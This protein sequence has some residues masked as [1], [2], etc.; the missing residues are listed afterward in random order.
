MKTFYRF[1]LVMGIIALSFTQSS[2]AQLSGTKTI[3]GDYATITAAITDLNT[4]G[5]GAGGV[6]FNVAAGFTE[7]ASNLVITATG[8]SAN[9][10]VFQ[11][12]GAGA[13]PLIT[14]GV[15]VGTMDGIIKLSGADYVTFDGFNLVDP[16]TNTTTT[17]QME[18]GFALLKVDGTNGSQYNTIRNCSITLQKVNTA[19][20]GIYSANHT[21]AATTALTVTSRTGSNSG[22]KYYSNYIQNCY[23]GFWMGGY[24]D[25][26]V[27]YDYYD[28]FNQIGVQGG[29]TI[30]YFG[31]GAVT[32]YGIYTIY[33]DSLAVNNNN[34]AGGSGTTTTGYGIMIST[35]NN[36]SVLVYNNTVSDTTSTTTSSTYGIALSNAGVGG[37]DNTVIVKRNTVQNMASIG[38]ITS[39][40]L[41]GFYIYY[42]VSMNLFV[43]SNKFINNKWGTATSTSTGSIYGIYIYPYTTTP[44]PGSTESITNNYVSG[45]NRKQSVVGTGTYYG[46]YIYYGQAA[47]E[48]YNNVVENDTL[49][50]TSAAYGMYVYNYY[51]NSANY[52]NNAVRNIYKKDGST[53]AY[54]G[55]YISGAA[56][57]GT[58]NYYN[59]SVNNI[60]VGAA[61]ASIYGHYNAAASLTKN[62]YGNTAYAL[63]TSLAGSV[64]GIYQSAG[65]TT[66]LYK[67]SV[68]NL[69]TSTGFGYG[70]TVA[71]G[72]TN[73]VYNNFISDIRV[74]SLS[75]TLALM[76]LYLSGGTT[77]NVYYNTI[78]LKS[79]SHIAG[80]FG[81]AALYASSV[82]AV[83][84][85]NNIVVNMSTPG[86]TGGYSVAYYRSTSTLTT[87]SAL[88]NNNCFYAGTP[89]TSHIVYYDGTNYLRTL[90]DFKVFVS[91]RDANSVSESPPFMNVT[92]T[93]YN[94][95]INP[96]IATQCEGSGTVISS[97]ISIV[98]DYDGIARY[99]NPGYPVNPSYPPAGPDIGAGE[100]GGIP[101]DMNPP[102]IA[103]TPLNHTATT[104]ARNLTAT[105]TD[106][107]GVPTSGIGLPVLY[108][109]INS[110]SYAAVTAVSLG[111]NR[112]SFTFGAGVALGDIISYYICAQDLNAPPNIGAFPSGGAGGYTLNP[113]AAAIPPTSPSTYTISAVALSGDYTVGLTMFNKITGKNITFEKVVKKVMKEVPV[114]EAVKELPNEK[115]KT[116][117]KDDN[118]TRDKISGRT[119]TIEVEEISWIP[120]ENGVEY[121]G[122]L[123]VKKSENPNY[124]YPSG[125]NGIYAT[126]TAAVADLNLRGVNGATRF[127]LNDASYTTGE[128]FPITVNVAND[129]IPTA[130]NT[131]T[132]KPNT[133]VTAAVSGAAASSRIFSIL[134]SY[135]SIDGS[136]TTNGTTRDLTIQNTSVTA[137]Q[138][139]LFGSKGTTPVTDGALKNCNIINGVNTSSAIVISDG[140]TPGT[141]GYFNNITI[142]NNSV[143]KAYIGIYA[144][145]NILAGNGSINI[146]ANNLNYPGA[147]AIRT[148]AIYAQGCN[149]ASVSNNYLGND[150]NIVDASN[151]TGIWFA[152]GTSN[153]T[154]SG[155]NISNIGGTLSGPRGIAI[156][157]A[158]PNANIVISG[159]TISGLYTPSSGVTYGIYAFSTT[160][161]VTIEKNRISNLRN[162]SASGYSAIGIA[163]ASTLTT[164]NTTVQNNFIWDVAAYGYGSTTTD[165]G[166]G[167]NIL[168]GGGYNIY[169]NSINLATDQTLATGNPAC[170]IISSSVVSPNSLDIRDNIFA[171]TSTLGTNRY[172]VLCNA[173]STVFS[174]LNNNDYYSTGPNLGRYNSAD[175]LDLAAWRT[176]LGKDSNSVSGDPKFFS[177]ADLHIMDSTSTTPVS[178]AGTPIAGL[179]TDLDGD[180]RNSTV[181]D[182]GADQFTSEL[183]SPAN[184]STGLENA[185]RLV[186]TKLTPAVS[187]RLQIATDTTSGTFV[188][189]TNVTDTAYTFLASN[190]KYY[191]RVNPVFAVYGNG[192]FSPVFNFS[193]LGTP[194]RVTLV[195]PSN[196]AVDLPV[197]IRF[198][199]NKAYDGT[200][201][202]NKPNAGAPIDISSYFNKTAKTNTGN[203]KFSTGD[204]VR[205]VGNYL[206]KISLDTTSAPVYADST[207]TDT[208]VVLSGAPPNQKFFWNVSA[209]NEFGWGATSVWFNATTIPMPGTPVAVSPPLDATGLASNV[210]LVWTHSFKAATY[211]V[212][213]STD[214]L[215][216]TL[217]F[218]DSLKTD[219]IRNVPG[220]LKFTK[221]YWRVK[222]V[223]GAGI[224]DWAT[225]YFTTANTPSPV[226]LV[227][228]NNVVHQPVGGILFT[229]RNLV[230]PNLMGYWLEATTD[231]V[232]G[233]PFM[234][235]STLGA[236]DTSKIEGGWGYFTNYYWRVKAKNDVNWGEYSI[237]FKFQTE[238]GPPNLVYPANNALGIV[239]T[240]TLDWDNAPGAATYRMQLSADSTFASTIL[241]VGGWPTSQYTVPSGL[242][243]IL[244]NY[245]W[246]VNS[247]NVNGTSIYSPV[248]K[249]RTMG[250]PLIVNLV[251]PVNNSI[252]VPALNTVFNWN[253]G[254]DQTFGIV[255]NKGKTGNDGKDLNA[256]NNGKITNGTDEITMVS[257]YWFELVTD[258]VAMANLVQDTTLTDTTKTIASLDN[259]TDFY[260]RVKGK[261]EI[262]WGSFSV[263][264]KFTTTVGLPALLLPANTSTDI[265]LSPLLDWTNGA[266]AT[267]YDLQVS[268]DP[269][270]ATLVY[271]L[272][273]LPTSEYSLPVPLN[274]FTNY[275]WRVR[276]TNAN[277]TSP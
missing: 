57:T 198:I 216:G 196:G 140:I 221:Y 74:D 250:E 89:D 8:T 148:I 257:K 207:L 102:T 247:T 222:A 210:T 55:I 232:T 86:T 180:T 167:I 138:V 214:S 219:T 25:A 256:K 47:V 181:P 83:D 97:P 62:F 6:T 260:F 76:G 263:W 58:F 11:K 18:W 130:V 1:I 266:T 189:N 183:L 30:R 5:V 21:I 95:H 31:G 38:A 14:A 77:D 49:P 81:T 172:A 211:T 185:V 270:F 60:S 118:S 146:N 169:Y 80:L 262:G 75:S 261:N 269:G 166:F 264:N 268:S 220:L 277:G 66:N 126:I 251:S 235:D 53:G 218:S 94:L 242:L 67:N 193:T 171:I 230:F 195:A 186:W 164:A 199:W 265:A 154:I 13:N 252:N 205:A 227:S 26:V 23:S 274:V 272:N 241:N 253:K 20:Y 249:F 69:R 267:S 109:K 259:M 78:Y 45:T 132:I 223:N 184:N 51:A 35:G 215:F 217:M 188:V 36:S 99:P 123:Y 237:Y 144:T 137:P 37:T 231:T 246:R 276:A 152:T 122:Q 73:N 194:T 63:R 161:V 158:V 33:Q 141:A 28:H 110:S 153:S 61:G 147:D 236:T 273:G 187:Y 212:E 131:V 116:P 106:P 125:V 240:V 225:S 124:N 162:T 111:A 103:Y 100:F 139:V 42:T 202:P 170:L 200:P 112:Y 90:S 128:T 135:V 151:I 117:R 190:L 209:K 71:G 239:P 115:G 40:A 174:N 157:S 191:W 7:T 119:K 150:S 65:T 19:S 213:M 113:P 93:P 70:I 96:A 9:P 68:Y 201:A 27:P 127:L 79:A 229:W 156:S 178:R 15:G 224:S 41:Y 54:Y 12:S 129:T 2:Y 104:T 24:A 244:S 160:S 234:I 243:T 173:L 182:I 84:L 254:V 175:V 255:G 22:N 59:N 204:N 34:I 206:I 248:F 64:Y 10:I 87:Y 136:N 46:M 4:Q 226:T 149:G 16:A 108:W 43:D 163:L 32:T 133:G 82:P 142:Q 168:S 233:I 85:R 29:N 121:D 105:I 203:E 176:A 50:T 114:D 143:K 228:P 107:S 197:T 39:G 48:A 159:N 238:V 165:N 3:P 177:A 88:S 208:T 271:D 72:T 17:T 52:Y 275:Y 155:N 101:I 44:T 192:S 145:A 92:T 98:D 258:T 179:T 56:T 134:N 120:L 91:P 245:F